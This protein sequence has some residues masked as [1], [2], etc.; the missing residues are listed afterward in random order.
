MQ[1][2]YLFLIAC[3]LF[4]F[5]GVSFLSAQTHDD[6]VY[7]IIG[8][9]ELLNGADW[10]PNASFNDMTQKGDIYELTVKNQHLV[11]TTSS[12]CHS[13]YYYAVVRNHDLTDAYPTILVNGEIRKNRGKNDGG[14]SQ[15]GDYDIVFTYNPNTKSLSANFILTKSEPNPTFTV[16]LTVN[17]PALGSVT[18]SGSYECGSYV[19]IKANPQAGSLFSGWSDGS[20]YA[21]RTIYPE[22]DTTIQAIFTTNSNIYTMVG[23]ADMMNNNADWDASQAVND[24]TLQSDGSYQLTVKN[25][26]LVKTSST[27]CHD[28]YYFAVVSDH[29]ITTSMP[30]VW[31]NDAVQRNRGANDGGQIRQTGMYDITY[32]FRPTASRPTVSFT[33]IE[34][35]PNP[36][37]TVNITSSDDAL[38]TVSGGGTYE[39]GQYITIKATPA[40]G[41]TFVQWSDGNKSASRTIYPNGDTDIY[42]IFQVNDN[43]YTIIGDPE[44]TNENADWDPTSEANRMTMLDDGTYR[45]IV[46]NKYLVKTSSASCHEHYYCAVVANHDM[47]TVKPTSVYRNDKLYRTS[48]TSDASQ[49]KQTGYYDITYTFTATA[50]RPT[51][52]YTLIESRPNPT[53]NVTLEVNDPLLGS[54]TG[55]G[56]YECGQSVNIRAVPAA[57]CTFTGWSDN[58]TTSTSRTIYPENDTTITATFSTTGYVL[59]GDPELLENGADWDVTSLANKMILQD[60]G[61]YQLVMEDRYLVK[62]SSSSCHDHY[63]FAVAQNGDMTTCKPSSVYRN[64]KLYRTSGVSD[65]SQI[66]QTGKYRITF[67]YKEGETRPT[68]TFTLVESM[69][70]PSFNVTVKSADETQG[71]VDAKDGEYECGDAVSIKA[72]A[73]ENHIFVKWSDGSTSASRTIYVSQDS[74]LVAYFEPYVWTVIGDLAIVN[75][76][77]AFNAGETLNDMVMGTKNTWTLTVENKVLTTCNSPYQFRVV[78]NHD[79]SEVRPTNT[80]ALLNVTQNGLY[81]ITFTY[82]Q[83]NSTPTVKAELLEEYGK[84][85]KFTFDI[86]VSNTA[87]GTVSGSGEYNC[88]EVVSIKATANDG[89]VFQQWSDGDTNPERDVLADRDLQLTAIFV[90]DGEDCGGPKEVY[91]DYNATSVPEQYKDAQPKWTAYPPALEGQIKEP[92][93]K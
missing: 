27:D 25:K 91:L 50:S 62:T 73:T 2:Q 8:D 4:L 3:L 30:N 43:S 1:K 34:S 60:D 88:G 21:S 44:V 18:G 45:L 90:C 16:T 26:Y 22:S 14:I 65:G 85:D 51:I 76:T 35:M 72:T 10:N 80:M 75:G 67:T 71:T 53:F 32:T 77:T 79:L 58:T 78:L 20:T 48:G 52:T 17:N 19:S 42:A 55:S 40:P 83:N 47:T 49:I 28:Y 57:G 39:C 86:Q 23:D 46:K 84:N 7:T 12:Y 92:D 82:R 87:Y 54:V 11:K 63:Y 41:S 37:Y 5:G 70:N 6:D 68:A 15:T 93:C 33:L 56:T 24:M 9:A 61:T 81:N 38:G 66:K 64:D 74:N 13:S 89:Y 31:R 36:T 69:P 29:D 59:I